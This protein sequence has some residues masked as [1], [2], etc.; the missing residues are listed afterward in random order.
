MKPIKMLGLAALAALMAMAFVG[1]SSAMAETTS[2]CSVDPG[3]GE[4]EVCP[5]GQL[6]KNIHETSV[7]RIFF[8]NS[9]LNVECEML[10]GGEVITAGLLGRPLEIKGNFKYSNCTSTCEV[11]ESTISALLKLLRE[12][13][14]RGSLTGEWKIK[15]HCGTFINCTYK[16]TGLKGTAKGPLLSSG[17]EPNGSVSL[18]EQV[19]QG[20]GLF[21][22]AEVKLDLL[23]T[24]LLPTYIAG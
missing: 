15:F 6:M 1:A 5:E 19:L 21:C 16:G 10:F 3:T 9:V 13:H 22:P 7:G 14:E 23:T 17:E 8:L 4:H 18:Q 12:G 24:P 11:T 20:S 2:L